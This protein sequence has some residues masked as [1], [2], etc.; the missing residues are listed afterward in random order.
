[1][2]SK[3]KYFS[4]SIVK[5]DTLTDR[6]IRFIVSTPNEDRVKDVMEP[7]GCDLTNYRHNPIVLVQHDVKSPIG[8]AEVEIKSDR[9]EAI[10]TFA[11]AGI[12]KKADE[13][14][15][16]AKAGVVRAVSVGYKELEVE[17]RKGGGL[18]IK[19]WELLEISLVAIP[20]N[21]D[22]I[23]IA[24]ADSNWKVGASRNLPV[25]ADAAWDAAAAAKGIFDK[26]EFDS[27]DA[28]TGFAR[29]GFLV[30]DAANA[31]DAAAYQIPFA[32]L[33]D[34]R[35]M[36]TRESIADAAAKLK[37]INLP[38]DVVEKARAV[39]AHYEGEMNKTKAIETAKPGKLKFKSL[40][41]VAQ[42]AYLLQELGYIEDCAEWEADYEGDDSKVPALLV[43]A[44]RQV[45]NALIAMTL[46]EIG[47]LLGE[48]IIVEVG[49]GLSPAA[50][51]KIKALKSPIA[52]AFAVARAKAG[53][54]FSAANQKSM[55]DAC[56]S[57]LCGHDAI[58]AL[59]DETD[60]GDEPDAETDTEKA[61]PPGVLSER[62]R[63]LEL[64]RL[65][66]C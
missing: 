49:K 51:A 13:Y 32:K 33:L 44:M 34:S 29:K 43:E 42:L 2:D 45:G 39:I 4:G 12:S 5:D 7:A 18:H 17:P 66:S 52:K 1:M 15:G 36:V 14:C 37:S 57:I 20:A 38:D 48:E 19:K 6:Q 61:L 27:D 41:D 10:V 11:P 24:K 40:Y 59:L 63:D 58:K 26:A 23:A 62:E 9:V 21:A 30:Y 64:L 28:D 46:E 50:A 8:N 22:A 31:S 25:A 53:R 56:K 60:S 35:L 16:L 65:K 55:E 54:K 3:L 47:E